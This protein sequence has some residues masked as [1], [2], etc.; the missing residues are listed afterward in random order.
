MRQL[1]YLTHVSNTNMEP[2]GLRK[3]RESHKKQ[4]RFCE[5]RAG[6]GSVLWAADVQQ[7]LYNV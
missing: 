3:G 6:S 7:Q 2:T 1:Y 4:L 5:R